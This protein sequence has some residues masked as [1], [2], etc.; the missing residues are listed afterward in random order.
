MN[1]KL[2]RAKWLTMHGTSRT[3]STNPEN[4]YRRHLKIMTMPGCLMSTRSLSF[5]ENMGNVHF[6]ATYMHAR[7]G[8]PP[9]REW[10]FDKG[11]VSLL[12]EFLPRI[13]WI[14]S[15]LLVLRITL[16]ESRVQCCVASWTCSK[17]YTSGPVNLRRSSSKLHKAIENLVLCRSRISGITDIQFEN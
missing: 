1:L 16:V 9:L 13:T 2:R 6:A 14:F 3:S 10:G 5:V 11:K 12:H 8:P 15:P 7:G 4:S 17:H